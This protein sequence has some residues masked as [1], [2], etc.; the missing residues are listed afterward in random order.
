MM[1]PFAAACSEARRYAST[2]IDRAAEAASAPTIFT[3]SS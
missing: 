3:A 1:T 2:E